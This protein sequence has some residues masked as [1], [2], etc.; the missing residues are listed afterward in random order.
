[1]RN[2][3]A[4]ALCLPLVACVVGTDPVGGGDDTGSGSG[5]GSGSGDGILGDITQST[6]W[7][8]D[9]KIGGNTT[10]AQGVTV[11]IAAGSTVTVKDGANITVN[12][13]L[14]A[15]G[16]SAAKVTLQPA[17]SAIGSVVVNASGE[18]RFKYVTM[19]TGYIRAVGGKL[20]IADSRMSRA[21]SDFVMMENGTIDMT[22][23]AV[24]VE[25][26]QTDTTHCDL[27]F[28]GGGNVIKVTHSNISSS[29]YGFM[30]YGGNAADM[31]YN[32]W[33]TNGV[34]I[35][36]ETGTT[37]S[38]NFSNSWF[39][40]GAPMNLAGVTVNAPSGARL[41]ACT[42]ANDATCAGPRP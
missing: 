4:L 7:S 22:Y 10:V 36:L 28:T 23:S 27:H 38:G 42:G 24:G 31:T 29:S 5:S 21:A 25:P 15:Q 16:T 6:T 40:K 37:V 11:T 9:V 32:N 18:L 2:A 13:I 19:T 12:G 20:T 3:L 14:D 17:T 35:A 41:A 33:F 30:F 8:G 26:G 39:E 34:D 1:M